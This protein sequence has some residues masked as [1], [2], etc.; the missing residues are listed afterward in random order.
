MTHVF[1]SRHLTRQTLLFLLCALLFATF[2]STAFGQT[3]TAP[4]IPLPAGVVSGNP[5]TTGI[6]L[7]KLIAGYLLVGVCAIAFLFAA[8][9][10]TVDIIAWY[11][12]KKTGGE[13][14]GK[15][16]GMTVIAVFC[17]LLAT[18]AITN[19]I[20]GAGGAIT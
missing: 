13:V 3:I 19:I 20:N 11:N 4:S 17:A 8:Y 10:A 15:A 7:G 6:S 9:G 2:A 18:F 5:I 16:L 12:G 1:P 14:Y